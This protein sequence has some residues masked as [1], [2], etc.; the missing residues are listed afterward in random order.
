M[1]QI[2]KIVKKNIKIWDY[3]ALR[4][5]IDSDLWFDKPVNNI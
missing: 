2:N 4:D 1:E 3:N 5:N